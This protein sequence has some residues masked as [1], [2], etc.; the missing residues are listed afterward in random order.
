VNGALLVVGIGNPGAEYAKT[1]HNLG[2]EVVDVLAKRWGVGDFRKKFHGLIA[3]LSERKVILIKPQTYVN[4]SGQSV[5]E[6]ATFYKL[7]P[8]SQILVLVDDL[9]LPPGQ[10]RLRVSG[11]SGGHNGLKSIIA[12]LGTEAFYRVRIGIGRAPGTESRNHVLS[13]IKKNEEQLY[14]DA[15]TAAADAVEVTLGEG[16]KMAMERFN[17]KPKVIDPPT[18]S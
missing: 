1:R 15:I 8:E 11:S 18:E 16:F 4:L 3:E 14:A 5:G 9:D 10:L 12:A 13:R 7:Q 6:A 17:R 2:F